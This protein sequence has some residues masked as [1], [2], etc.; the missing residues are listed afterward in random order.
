MHF[1]VDSGIHGCGLEIKNGGLESLV[2]VM[3]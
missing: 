3:Y 1:D 2:L